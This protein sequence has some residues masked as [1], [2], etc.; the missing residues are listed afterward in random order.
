MD[1][2]DPELGKI[3]G[4]NYKLGIIQTS[5]DSLHHAVKNLQETISALIKQV[6]DG[7]T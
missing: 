5:V 6:N 7:K 1:E 3:L 4:I 2:Y